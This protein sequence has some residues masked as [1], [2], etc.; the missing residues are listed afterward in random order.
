MSIPETELTRPWWEAT[1]QS[2]LLLQT[3]AGCGHRQHH[4]RHRCLS[5]GGDEL[6]WSTSDGAGVID[7]VTVVHRSPRTDLEVPYPVAR[8]RLDDGP[9]LLTTLVDGDPE[10]WRIGDAVALR[11][12]DLADDDRRLPVWG[13]P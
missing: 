1:R 6:G 7:A 5:C 8:V 4:P 12:R 13:R 2:R 11:W 10:S 3:C 9:V